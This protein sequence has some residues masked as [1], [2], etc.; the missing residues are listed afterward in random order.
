MVSTGYIQYYIQYYIQHYI[1]HYIQQAATQTPLRPKV[2]DGQR[3]A[4]DQGPPGDGAQIPGLTD[5]R[6]PGWERISGHAGGATLRHG[7][8]KT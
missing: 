2:S 7:R 4:A 1:Q 6:W 3:R 5:Q 8:M